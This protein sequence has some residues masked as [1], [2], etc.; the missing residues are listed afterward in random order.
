MQEEAS[1]FSHHLNGADLDGGFEELAAASEKVTL[2]LPPPVEDEGDGAEEGDDEEDG[3]DDAG[4]G[5]GG[6][7]VVV[8][9]LLAPGA[10]RRDG[11][12]SR[13][14]AVFDVD[15]GRDVDGA[16][17]GEERGL[18]ESGRGGLEGVVDPVG[19]EVEEEGE[20]ASRLRGRGGD[21]VVDVD[22]VVARRGGRDDGCGVD[23][24]KN[25]DGSLE[26]DPV[27]GRVLLR[28]PGDRE[29]RRHRGEDVLGRRRRGPR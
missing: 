5:G 24:G 7:G 16:D 3:D 27:R 15:H 23:L 2:L 13:D 25:R 22:E 11:S 26:D 17:A 1:V 28:D 29:R 12:G 14:A 19:S 18:V 20:D 6:E 9:A 4:D 10:R 8:V 21:R